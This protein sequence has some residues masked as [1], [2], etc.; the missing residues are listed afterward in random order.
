MK[1]FVVNSQNTELFDEVD[2]PMPEATGRDLLVEVKAASLNPVDTKVRNARAGQVLGWD[3]AGI[4]T[5]VGD[6]VTGF[7]VGDSVYYAGDIGRPGSNANYQLVDERIVG[8]KPTSLNFVEACAIPLTALTAWEGLYEQLNVERGKSILVIG[9]AGGVGSLAVQMARRISDMTVIGTASRPETI[10]WSR[11]MGAT[12]VIDHHQ[13]IPSQIRALGLDTVDYIICCQATA[14]HFEAMAEI[15][16][17]QGRIVSIV[18]HEHP[19]PL[20]KLFA[21]KASFAW[22]LMFTKSMYQTEDM[23]SQ[24]DILNR[25][26]SLLDQGVL[27][28]TLSHDGGALTAEALS[29]AHKRQAS[30]TMIGK[31]AFH[32]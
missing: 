22:E 10:E 2:L 32:L 28:C 17:P 25:V 6:R 27:E 13:D 7:A 1:A 4:V 29:E 3:A 16:T 31:Q 5:A 9:S 24:G 20:G 21:K 14:H 19:L 12:H 8:L 11:R 18:E 26:A 15:I 30:G 23:A